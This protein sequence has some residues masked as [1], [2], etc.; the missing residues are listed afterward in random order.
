MSSIR[1]SG[2][3]LFRSKFKTLFR[4]AIETS[5]LESTSSNANSDF[6]YSEK[7]SLHYKF[8]KISNMFTILLAAKSL[9]SSKVKS[10]D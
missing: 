3:F 6:N 2:I 9:K 7:E 8:D 5:P 1:S 10:V 4:F